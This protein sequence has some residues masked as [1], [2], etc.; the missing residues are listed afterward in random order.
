MELGEAPPDALDVV[1]VHRAVGAV[2]VDPEADPLGEALPLV[3]VGQ[4]RLA[5]ERVEL[6][7]AVGLD[8]R[9]ARDA[10]ALL[11]LDLHRQAVAVPAAAPVHEAPAHG[12]EAR[13]D[14]L[15]DAREHV[16]RRR[17]ARWRWAGPRRTR[18]ARRP[19]RCG[20]A[21]RED[22]ALAPEGEHALLHLPPGRGR[23]DRPPA[24]AHAARVAAGARA[25]RR[26]STKSSNG[27]K[28]TPLGRQVARQVRRGRRRGRPILRDAPVGDAVAH[29]D[30][31][32]RPGGA[33]RRSWRLQRPPAQRAA[34]APV[35]PEELQPSAV[36][37]ASWLTTSRS[38]R[39]QCASSGVDHRAEAGREHD[40]AVA[41][42]SRAQ[43]TSS[44]EAGAQAGLAQHQLAH[45]RRGVARTEA[46]SSC[47]AC[48]TRH[49]AGP[50][51]RLD[52]AP[53]AR[54]CRT[55]RRSGGACP[56]R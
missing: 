38:A 6:G 18:T 19:A 29:V 39:P 16:V 15:E 10:E 31:A 45:L 48:S 9:L 55:P 23:G 33:P 44:A 11:H 27:M 2:G 25:A 22:V 32:A 47:I 4:H 21:A 3:E 17:G 20:Q 54:A 56:A 50:Q 1:R 53:T 40:Q 49:L 24:V 46:N 35:G 5:A 7:D 42:A 36:K 37:R 30:H 52:G 26:T 8:L 12:L 51:A 13:E 14:V 43:S 41:P 34:L 28:G